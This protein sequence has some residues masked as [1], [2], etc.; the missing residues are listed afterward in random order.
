SLCGDCGDSFL[1]MSTSG[2][3]LLTGYFT[4]DDQ[5]VLAN[6]DIDLGSGGLILLPDSLGSA[7]HPHLLLGGGK[8]G[9]LYL[10]DRDNLGSYSSTSNQIVQE[11]S[12]TSGGD[13]SGFYSTPALWQNNVYVLAVDDYLKAFQINSGMLT[14]TPTSESPASGGTYSFPGATPTVSASGSTNGI[15]WV[16]SASASFSNGPA[17][18]HAYDATNLSNQLYDSTQ[19]ANNR[20]QA[21]PAVRFAVPTVA[22]GK[23]Y[24]GGETQLTVY[25]LLPN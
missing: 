14:T 20:D 19:A 11:L 25:G 3:L 22:N 24:I 16:L 12:I 6:G 23:V 21:G 1:K 7:T 13:L 9:H 4:P 18:L 10:V 15:V 5:S 8:T 2:G 17:I